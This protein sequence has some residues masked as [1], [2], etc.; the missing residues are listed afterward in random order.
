MTSQRFLSHFNVW[1]ATFLAPTKQ[2]KVYEQHGKTELSVS[3]GYPTFGVGTCKLSCM[4]AVGRIFFV[5]S[6]QRAVRV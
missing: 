5:A 3:F 2:V 6:T 4:D 1:I